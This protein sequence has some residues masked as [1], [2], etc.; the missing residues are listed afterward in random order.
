MNEEFE[1]PWIIFCIRNSQLLR[2][3]LKKHWEKNN[4]PSIIT[5]INKIEN[6][7]PFRTKTGHYV[8]LLTSEV[9]KL[10]G[11][12][13]SKIAKDEKGENFPNLEITEVV[14][15][16]CN[17][18][19]NNYQQ[20]LKVLYTF[21]LNKSFGQLLDISH[22]NLTHLK[23]FNSEFPYIKV[24]FDYQNSEPLEIGD[25]TNVILVINESEKY[26]KWD[27]IQFQLWQKYL[28]KTI[29]FCIL[30]KVWVKIFVKM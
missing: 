23:S 8:Q 26:K 7:I 4:N 27:D 3:Y 28:W 2:I 9:V 13:N 19:N 16:H 25:K 21:I 24:R 1:L 17:I 22:K 12:G 5:Y 18:V 20:D 15:V 6:R 11:S 14:L 30:L 29:N 10:L